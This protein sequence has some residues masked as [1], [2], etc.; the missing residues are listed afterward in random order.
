M[1]ATYIQRLCLNV[2]L[3]A[4][5]LPVYSQSTGITQNTQDTFGKNRIQYKNFDWKVISTVNFE[6][7]YYQE[8][9]EIAYFAA[10]H[11]E[12]DFDRIAD[13][14]GY[15]P[16]SKTKVFIYNSITDLQQSNVGLDDNNAMV[17]GQTNFIK[18]RVEIPYTG[19]ATTFKKELSL[20]IA[21]MFIVEM[22]FGGSLKD[23]VQSS[24]LLTLPDW[25]MSGAAAYVAEGWS[26]EMDDYVRD[27]IVNKNMRRPAV[28]TGKDAVLVGQSIWNFVAERYGKSNIS[29]ILNL[30]RIIRNEE[31]SIGST[32]GLPY[33]R[34]LNEW[35]NYY[36][37][38][39]AGITNAYKMPDED[40]RVRRNNRNR[41]IYNQLEISPNGKNLAYS[42][43]LEGKYNVYFR[44]TKG[45]K[46]RS[47]M[48]GGYKSI[49]QRIDPEVPLVAWRNNSNLLVIHVLRGQY[50]LSS[51][52]VTKRFGKRVSRKELGSF[53][54]VKDF[55]VSDDGK[56]L[57]LSADR[58]GKNDIFLYD[59]A[60][61][62]VS[63]LT[64]DLFDDLNPQFLAGSNSAVVFSSNRSSDTLNTDKG[65][66][67]TITDR[68]DLF[69]YDAARSTKS[70]NRLGYSFGNETQP[71]VVNEQTLFYLSDESG[72]TQLY[73]Y[74][75]PSGKVAQLSNFRQNIQ[76]YHA[77]LADSSLAYLMLDD[78]RNYIGFDKNFS[79]SANLSSIRTKRSELLE[80][81]L[82]S[83][84]NRPGYSKANTAVAKDS[85]SSTPVIVENQLVL[86][87][88]E[89]DTDNYKFDIDPK[90][91][92]ED[93]TTK[94]TRG[95]NSLI[96]PLADNSKKQNI[97]IQ[98]PY[99][100]Q[101]R[102]TTDNVISSV[103]I[104]PLRGLGVLFNISMNDV[105][106]NH[107]INGGILAFTDLQ[108]SNFFGEYRY[109][110]HRIDFGARYDKKTLFINQ[111]SEGI[112][113]RYNLN[114]IQVSASYPF[115]V[116]S[117]ITVAPFVT[118]TNFS[119]LYPTQLHKADAN[120]T[121]GGFRT[122]FV[123]DNTVINGLN[124]IEGTRMKIKY[125]NY[126]AFNAAAQSFNNISI[127]LRNYKK[128]HRDIIFA[129]RLAFGSF[130]GRAPKKYL[131]GGM[132]NWIFN[133]KESRANTEPDPLR[134]AQGVDSRDL[135]FA[136]FMTNL[137]GFNYNKLYG[138]NFLL[139]NGELRFPVVKYF[140]RGPITSNFFKNLQVVGFADIGTAWT[141]KGPFSRQNSLNTNI[142]KS[143]PFTA[144]VTN[145]KNPFLSGYGVGART[146]LLG[147][148]VK[149]DVAWGMEDYVLANKPKLYLT[150]GY[151]F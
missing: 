132:D 59:F 27:A 84:F 75:I 104:D 137:R 120:T 55:D 128:I 87:E 56:T 49:N 109:L 73:R 32:L 9:N 90:K 115:T 93:N 146:L 47:V 135:L 148:Y 68:F 17:G 114:K 102:F 95:N 23:M 151:D 48:T 51:F 116:A 12:S 37:N 40:F 105:L 4:F 108:S 112:I 63:Q 53:N 62:S 22:M 133:N 31:N 79:F 122:E 20:G 36:T 43:N 2:L 110:K 141:G 35:R 11:A 138:N 85:A 60:R 76:T 147:Y 91:T 97:T 107:H 126:Q 71:Q 113:Q 19:S 21:R 86:E 44:S 121:Y 52:D 26:N 144:S 39:N 101:N 139:F 50:Y 117:R 13:L 125:E 61:G 74:D 80:E 103:L 118:N 98:G 88:G 64:N 30:T 78:R 28:Q 123:F 142:I 29:N 134:V 100:Y 8:A 69:V 143:G 140:Y 33:N 119:D 16:Y 130:G 5:I 25:F 72:V 18:S 99:K 1:S 6:I 57:V 24:Y 83:S 124:M 94:P 92:K 41:F 149:F 15:T 65:A 111:G 66:F 136:E 58:A 46:K 3:L 89:I 10:R 131:L 127:D 81:R 38:M 7:Y 45:G 145:F 67:N 96:N 54:Q 70:L 129:S 150:L 106:E 42:E 82:G 14:L 77:N 34:F